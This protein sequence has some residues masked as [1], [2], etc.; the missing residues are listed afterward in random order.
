MKFTLCVRHCIYPEVSRTFNFGRKGVS[1]GL[2]YEQHIGRIILNQQPALFTGYD[3]HALRLLGDEELPKTYPFDL[4]QSGGK[5]DVRWFLPQDY[6]PPFLQ[7]VYDYSSETKTEELKQLLASD[8]PDTFSIY[9]Q[10]KNLRAPNDPYYACGPQCTRSFLL[11]YPL[12]D[13][14]A[15]KNGLG[16]QVKL[17]ETWALMEDI[18]EDVARVSYKNVVTFKQ[19]LEKSNEWIRIYIAPIKS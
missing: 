18:R 10:N 16:A 1:G 4:T 7:S 3:K 6:D 12:N 19:K 2:F 5:I 8:Q 11:L 14:S 15:G 13:F 9:R 17:L